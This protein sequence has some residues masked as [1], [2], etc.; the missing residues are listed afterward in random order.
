[1]GWHKQKKVFGS[2][3]MNY[4]V[5]K[6]TANSSYQ[7]CFVAYDIILYNDKL[8]VNLPYKERLNILNDAFQ[9]EEGSLI[10]C[11]SKIIS[12]R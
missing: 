2:K 1:M 11:Q 4:D 12:N 10:K 7:P 9:D 6:L 8:L 3:G 5:K